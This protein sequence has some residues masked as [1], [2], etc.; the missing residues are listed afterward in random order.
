MM[1]TFETFIEDGTNRM[2][3]SACKAVTEQIGEFFNPLWICGPSGCGKTHLL[4]AVYH[5]IDKLKSQSVLYLTAKDLVESLIKFH[6]KD[7]TLWRAIEMVDVLLI[8]N[9]EDLCGR[10]ATQDELAKLILKKSTS[11]KQVILASNC[12]PVRL[13]TLSKML[14]S[15]AEN[16]LFIDIQDSTCELRSKFANMFLKNHPINISDDAVECLV[17]NLTTVPQIMGVLRIA[18]FWNIQRGVHID[19]VWIKN[20]IDDFK[21]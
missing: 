20:Y 3:V 17:V 13:A 18:E 4:R 7:T 21:R 8:D 11:E 2:A 12:P 15:T 9:I 16:A 19:K 14:L 5:N 6:R 1:F 10:S